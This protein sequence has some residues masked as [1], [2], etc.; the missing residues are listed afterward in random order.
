MSTPRE[1]YLCSEGGCPTSTHE[2]VVVY[3]S[4]RGRRGYHH[5]MPYRDTLPTL[6]EDLSEFARIHTGPGSWS[7]DTNFESVPARPDAQTP[8][9]PAVDTR[10]SAILPPVRARSTQL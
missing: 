9:A 10:R 7:A 2:S 5:V 4:P 1:S 3:F 8:Q 6:P